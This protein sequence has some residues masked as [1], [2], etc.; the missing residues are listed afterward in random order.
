MK[1]PQV[2]KQ[3]NR[4]EIFAD[5]PRPPVRFDTEELGIGFIKRWN[6]LEGA[7]WVKF[8]GLQARDEAKNLVNP[9]IFR[10]KCIQ[11]SFCEADSKLVFTTDDVM[12]IAANLQEAT[13]RQLYAEACRVNCLTDEEVAKARDFFSKI[14][15]NSSGTDSRGTSEP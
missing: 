2:V 12:K 14:Q 1:K 11:L 4:D 10:A 3:L 15:P 8:I 9:E 5:R 13:L 7:E 6:G